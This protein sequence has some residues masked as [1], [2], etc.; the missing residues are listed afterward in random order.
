MHG[1]LTAFKARANTAAGTSHLALVAFA[2]GFA[3]A[4]A[5][6]AADTLA[7][8]TGTR[9]VFCVLEQHDDRKGKLLEMGS[10]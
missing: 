5:F 9:A 7:A 2:G 10:A 6:S 3:M 8:L 1:H 4:G